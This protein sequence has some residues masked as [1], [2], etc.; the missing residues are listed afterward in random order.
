ME[1]F[2]HL[3][4]QQLYYLVNAEV[5]RIHDKGVGSWLH[6]GE[7]ARSVLTVA[8]Q[9]LPQHL[10]ISNVDTVSAQLF[11]ASPRSHFGRCRQKEFALGMW[12]NFRTLIAPFGDQVS[13]L[14]NLAL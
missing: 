10:F 7:S 9:L 14:T 6:G 13:P 3:G 8:L 5:T 4:F 2:V 11:P 1:P 12:K